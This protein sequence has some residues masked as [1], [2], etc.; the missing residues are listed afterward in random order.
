MET[1]MLK[2]IMICMTQSGLAIKGGDTLVGRPIKT[3]IDSIH[4]NV[5][6]FDDIKVVDLG[7]KFGPLGEV[8]LVRIYLIIGANGYY[9]EFNERLVLAIVKSIGNKW[10]KN[11][12]VIR[13]VIDY[14]GQCGLFDYDLLRQNIITSV[15]IQKR[16]EY[17]KSRNKAYKY[18][19]SKYWLL[20]NEADKGD[21]LPLNHYDGVNGDL[22]GV[23]ANK[24]VENAYKKER[25]KEKKESRENK[26]FSLSQKK[27]HDAFPDKAIDC[28]IPDNCDIDKIIAALRESEFWRT[29]KNITLKSCIKQYDKLTAGAYK[30]FKR[31]NNK[32]TVGF[33]RR[34]YTKEQLD[35]MFTSIDDFEV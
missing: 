8:V 2:S 24:P 17:I 33:Q 14:C 27:F 3:G 1:S 16:Y 6:F 9:T 10:L 35:A 30:D 13:D 15:G 20:D 31:A 25:N 4:L 29:Q 21:L 19:K 12:E 11:R 26:E 22:H 5:G 28:D 18:D 23:N 7:D 34:E 32:D